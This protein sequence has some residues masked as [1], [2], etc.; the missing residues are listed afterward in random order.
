MSGGAWRCLGA[1]VITVTGYSASVH[2]LHPMYLA[3]CRTASLRAF[4][5]EI[6]DPRTPIRMIWSVGSAVVCERFFGSCF[7]DSHDTIRLD[8]EPKEM[9]AGSY[10]AMACLI[11]VF[12]TEQPH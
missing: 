11:S 1:R 9:R 5:S 4:A 6:Q 3:Q 2:P 8:T 7:G 12:G 10:T